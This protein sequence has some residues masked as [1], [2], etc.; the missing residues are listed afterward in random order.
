MGTHRRSTGWTVSAF[1]MAGVGCLAAPLSTPAQSIRYV[2]Q[3]RGI[4][5]SNT[6]EFFQSEPEPGY[7]RRHDS[8]AATAPDFAPFDARVSASAYFGGYSNISQHSALRPDGIS[9]RGDWSAQA[10]TDN[11]VFSFETLADVTF[12]VT[13]APAQFDFAYSLK[14][15]P[16]RGYARQV[17]L[18][19]RRVDGGG[20]DVFRVV[21]AYDP[22]LYTASGTASG[23]LSP[24]RYEFRYFS[25]YLGDV[26][27]FGSYDVRLSLAAVPEPASVGVVLLVGGAFAVRRR[28]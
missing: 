26:G 22:D 7:V 4:A 13:D 2:S 6:E 12:D 28:R 11:G 15:S 1:V 14:D 20:G 17:D 5:A 16:Y 9:A 3:E 18:F 24:G 21:P 19:L 10:A 23:V 27:D 25:M 8:D